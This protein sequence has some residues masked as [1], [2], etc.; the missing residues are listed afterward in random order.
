MGS[1]YPTL[2]RQGRRA[3]ASKLAIIEAAGEVLSE[4]GAQGFTLDA[5]AER[6]DVVVQTIYNRVGNRTA[7][8]VAVVERAVVENRRYVD[9]AYTSGAPAEERIRAA[10][11]AYARFALERPHQF[12]LIT[13]PPDDPEVLA[14]TDELISL[15]MHHLA[16]ALREASIEGAVGTD[17]DPDI[18]APA[19][20]AMCSGVLMLGTRASRTPVTGTQLTQFLDFVAATITHGIKPQQT[21]RT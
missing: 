12:K 17:L 11:S 7:L 10:F 19:L 9:A 3:E 5:V 13:S 18:A 2:G 4:R 20:W 8:M 16:G 21:D 14:R 15:H 1:P 6:A